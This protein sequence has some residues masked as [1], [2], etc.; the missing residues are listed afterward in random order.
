MDKKLMICSHSEFCQ[1]GHGECD[2]SRPHEYSAECCEDH[3][4]CLGPY[5]KNCVVATRRRI[6]AAKE[7]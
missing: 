2:A 7:V 5:S 4:R 6:A 1:F 3:G